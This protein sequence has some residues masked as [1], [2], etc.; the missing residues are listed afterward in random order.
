MRSSL[1]HR[2]A[3]MPNRL[4]RAAFLNFHIPSGDRI[5]WV[6]PFVLA[7]LLQACATGGVISLSVQ[8][9]AKMSDADICYLDLF[10]PV[11]FVPM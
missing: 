9:V 10:A 5:L 3:S 4:L 6:L 11:G 7:V 1:I 8:D 2:E